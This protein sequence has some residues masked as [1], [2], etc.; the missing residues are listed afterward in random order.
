MGVQSQCFGGT[1]IQKKK[2]KGRREE[3]EEEGKGEGKKE[4]EEEEEGR[5]RGRGG[6]RTCGFLELQRSGKTHSD[7]NDIMDNYSYHH[8]KFMLTQHLNQTTSSRDH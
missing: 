3:E 6:G 5:V 1:Y 2:K 4:E 8:E 7:E